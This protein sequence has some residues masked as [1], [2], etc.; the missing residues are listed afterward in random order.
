MS[1]AATIAVIGT[2]DM[3]S[4]VGG[5]LVRAGFRTVTDLTRAQRAVARARGAFRD[6]RLGLVA[7]GR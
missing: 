7:R 2:G 5:A 1:S 3:G 6:R 4:A